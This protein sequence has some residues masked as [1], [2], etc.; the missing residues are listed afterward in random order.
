[1][2]LDTRAVHGGRE[3]LGQAHVPPIDLSTTYKT[4]DLHAATRSI[5]GMA[6]GGLPN[7]GSIYQLSLIHI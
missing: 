7:G 1:M 3:G 5:D 4:P 6:E 2:R